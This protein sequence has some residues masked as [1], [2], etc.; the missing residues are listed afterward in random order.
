MHSMMIRHFNKTTTEML[1]ANPF[2]NI[3]SEYKQLKETDPIRD[4]L[5]FNFIMD[6]FEKQIKPAC[7]VSRDL[8]TRD[9]IKIPDYLDLHGA[10]RILRSFIKS[11]SLTR[12][13][14][15]TWVVTHN[16]VLHWCIDKTV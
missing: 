13:V 12:N 14:V 6:V 11:N 15:T 8:I 3:F 10:K 2:R 7:G 9:Y 5:L 4:E 16:R 1:V